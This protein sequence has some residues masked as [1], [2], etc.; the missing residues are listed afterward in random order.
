MTA[1][2]QWVG[3]V[4]ALLVSAAASATERVE[5]RFALPLPS[6]QGID[7]RLLRPAQAA[8]PLPAII[9]LGGFQRGTG[10]LDLVVTER[11]VVLAGFD[12][13]LA[14]PRKLRWRDLP[15]LIPQARRAVVDTRAGVAALYAELRRRPD[16]DP[17]RVTVVGASA[18][19]PF[20]TLAAADAGIPA[21]VV[22]HGFADLRQVI[23]HQFAR[24]WE[25]QYGR[26]GRW[27]ARLAARYLHWSLQLPSIES[28]A[29]R[30]DA[31]QRVLMIR[32][33]EDAFVPEAASDALWHSLQRSPA[34]VTK[35]VQP[36]G[37]VRGR[38]EEE[39]R[40]ILDASLQWLQ[41][42]QLI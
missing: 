16:V 6:G 22:V 27:A 7:V 3:L 10:A 11:P 25:R 30:L 4:A 42:E 36:G 8:A 21:L 1:R 38:S 34:Q 24:R 18:G 40:R 41:Q 2:R 13:P 5:E 31:T 19:A 32:A 28:A 9:L 26:A 17:R 33:E 29:L 39:L 14:A 37:H 12:Y 15:W 20:A 23:E 35:I